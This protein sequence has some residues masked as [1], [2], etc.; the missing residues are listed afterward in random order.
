MSLPHWGKEGQKRLKSAKVVVAGAGGLGCPVSLY[1]T[2]AGIGK[3]TIIDKDKFE[4]SNL[5]RQILGWQRDLGSFKAKVVAEKLVAL[6]PEI[7]VHPLVIEITEE[8]IG[9]LIQD[10]NVVIDA[11]DNWKTRFIINTECV[12]RKIPFI[13][14]GISGLY[15]Q[16]M[17]II[18]GKTPCLLCL[19]PETPKEVS[20]FPVLG[21]TPSIFASLQVME[22]IKLIVGFGE[23]LTRKM[24]LFDLESM[25]FTIIPVERNPKCP[26]CGHLT[27]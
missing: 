11:M 15:G 9:E 21:V 16:I 25:N 20:N 14:A 27:K 17:T 8:N 5:N 6:N 26:I 13:H 12:K 7:K 18:P 23:T 2:A 4:L 3:L 1:L 10:A 19:L 24:L 22:T